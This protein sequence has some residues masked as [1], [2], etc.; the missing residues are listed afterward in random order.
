MFMFYIKRLFY[1]IVCA[2][3]TFSTYAIQPEGKEVV[4][5]LQTGKVITQ[6]PMGQ[7]LDS[8]G[9]KKEFDNEVF[10]VTLDNGLKAVFKPD[11]M[12]AACAEIA[13]YQ[14]SLKLGFPYK[15]PPTTIRTID[16]R[17]GSLQLFIETSIDPLAPGI[18]G[19]ALKEVDPEALAN[20]KIFYFVF[21]QW[22]SGPHNLL[23]CKDQGKT[24]F[25]AIDNAA[26]QSMQYVRYGELP[27]VRVSYSDALHTNDW[28]QP[29]PF[30]RAQEVKHPSKELRKKFGNIFPEHFYNSLEKHSKQPLRYV[31][32]RN[33]LWKQYHAFDD[34]FVKSHSKFCPQQTRKALEMLNLAMLRELFPTVKGADFVTDDYL[35]AILERRD[36]VLQHCT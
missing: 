25:V 24:S 29:F 34:G 1:I 3:P 26:I 33:A 27:F 30:D 2:M 31:I 32:Y 21:G 10:L 22:D 15:I 16:D 8:Q 7:V 4:A 35:N 12:G 19:Q 18:Y 36:Q 5:L 13:A 17:T 14:A 6:Q 20:L 23:I 11:D 9:K 28:D